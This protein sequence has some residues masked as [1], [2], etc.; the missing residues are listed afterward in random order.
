MGQVRTSESLVEINPD[1]GDTFVLSNIGNQYDVD[2]L[3][4]TPDRLYFI[5]RNDGLLY[6]Y[7]RGISI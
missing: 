4:A 1:F 2:Y 7:F 6:E 5:S 3:G